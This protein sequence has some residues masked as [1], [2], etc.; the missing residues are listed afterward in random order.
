MNY[1]AKYGANGGSLNKQLR[2]HQPTNE[3]D[4]LSKYAYNKQ[5]E[6]IDSYTIPIL[7]NSQ[8]GSIAA[9]HCPLNY[10]KNILGYQN[11]SNDYYRIS[12]LETNIYQPHD[13][14]SSPQHLPHHRGNNQQFMHNEWIKKNLEN[15]RNYFEPRYN[16]LLVNVEKK[17]KFPF[18]IFGNPGPK[19]NTTNGL[20]DHDPFLIMPTA[21]SVNLSHELRI[22][23]GLYFM[24]VA[25]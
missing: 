7:M 5:N 18:I 4:T 13:M 17:A 22:T 11:S 19:F 12:F 16:E 25:F 8:F 15:L 3:I 2:A 23:D 6:I 1:N 14:P 21:T 24:G 10:E 9:T 20:V